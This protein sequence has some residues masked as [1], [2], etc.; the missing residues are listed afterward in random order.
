M[1]IDTLAGLVVDSAL[2]GLIIYGAAGLVALASRR[3]AAA[4]RHLAWSVATV[5]VLALPVFSASLPSWELPLRL[6][7]PNAVPVAQTQIEPVSSS[8]DSGPEAATIDEP[9]VARAATDSVLVSDRPP[10][11]PPAVPA[12][13][14]LGLQGVSLG[15]WL[16]GLWAA[17][18][19][20]TLLPAAAGLLSLRRL[21]RVPGPVAAGAAEAVLERVAGQLGLTRSV[22]LVWSRERVMPMTWGVW[23]PVI[24]LP[25]S[26]ESWTEERLEMV[27][28]HELAHVKRGDF[29]IMMLACLARAWH[30]FNPLA[31]LACFR[32]RVEQEHACDD[33]ALGRG[34][35]PSCYAAHLLAV[36]AQGGSGRRGRVQA[37]T[38]AS[39]P[40][41]GIERRLRSILDPSRARCPLSRRRLSVAAALAMCLLAPLAAGRLGFTA[42]PPEGAAAASAPKEVAA[43]DQGFA[44]QQ[45]DVLE[46]LRRLYVK[47]PDESALRAGAIKGMVDSLHDPYSSY[48]GPEELRGIEAQ[49]R[50]S[51]S[52][53]GARLRL[54]DKLVT[55]EG[56]LPG[57]PAE[58]AGIVPGDVIVEAEGQPLEGLDL[59]EVVKKVIGPAG[60][61]VRLKIKHR[62]G[63]EELLEIT[64]STIALRS[65]RGPRVGLE[66]PRWL[67][68]PARTIAYMLVEQFASAT[69]GELRDAVHALQAEGMKGLI[70][71]L[72]SCPG[73]LLQGASEVANLFLSDGTIVT[74]RGR[75]DAETVV[76]VEPGK[77]LGEFPLLV[78]VNEQTASA[79]EIVAGALKDH[80][81]AVLVG[82]RT[83]GKGSVQSL[84]KLKEGG[85]ALRLTTSYYTLPSGRNINRAEGKAAWGVDPSEG[86]FVPMDLRRLEAIRER[87]LNRDPAQTAPAVDPDDLQLAAGLKAMAARLAT[88]TFARVGLSTTD[89]TAQI[90]RREEIEKQRTALLGDLEKLDQEL[91]ALNQ[92]GPKPGPS[93]DKG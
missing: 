42:P 63:R 62:D 13:P 33:L 48:L 46:Q 43:N 18:A 54:V 72:R 15:T 44:Q 9:P 17:G 53:V 61:L 38:M 82:T 57:S 92:G 69:P 34:L 88:G 31:W 50:G 87:Q 86:D 25:D 37:V 3:A 16:V 85:G 4:T 68:D 77:A 36:V 29:A 26:A 41:R 24:L 39:A 52:G 90:Q 21:G 58:K 73:G 8:P 60:T 93:P 7:A 14:R 10:A 55:I 67:I 6:K 20:L 49:L 40:A 35:D 65:V 75:D 5:A 51:M 11:V 66:P 45:A 81:R 30:W 47:A 84:I 70:L 76:R 2:K 64:R 32:L 74:F 78:L 79:A 71:D 91:G 59:A 1:G 23:R 27:I 28:L 12:L 89:L 56:T 19:V 83:H 22:R 80:G